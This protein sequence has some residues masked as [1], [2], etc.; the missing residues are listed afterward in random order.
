MR[1]TM[2]KF[3][4]YCCYSNGNEIYDRK[5]LSFSN[6]IEHEKRVIEY[7]N[8]LQPPTVTKDKNL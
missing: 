2:T 3:I 8:L 4:Y 6:H 5:I 7:I 1:F